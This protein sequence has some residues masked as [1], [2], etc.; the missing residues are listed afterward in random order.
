MT[1]IKEMYDAEG[2][3]EVMCKDMCKN[4]KGKDYCKQYKMK[5]NPIRHRFC[6]GF[7]AF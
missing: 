6:S 3:I 7:D 5:V 1:E 2:C 4:F